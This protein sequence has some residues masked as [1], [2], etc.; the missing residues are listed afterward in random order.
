MID[1][2]YQCGVG[3]ALGG[4]GSGFRVVE[5]SPPPDVPIAA[6]PTCGIGGA[7]AKTLGTRETGAPRSGP[8]RVGA[9][10]H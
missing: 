10:A 5:P 6:P 3:P 1:D 4:R 9:T 2:R 7:A 8:P